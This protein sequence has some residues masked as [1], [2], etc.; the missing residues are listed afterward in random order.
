MTNEQK[1]VKGFAIFLAAVICISILSAALNLIGFLFSWTVDTDEPSNTSI[2]LNRNIDKID[3]DLGALNLEIYRGE[4]FTV[5]KENYRG[6]VDIKTVGST[7]KI[8]EKHN[9]F[10]NH[11]SGTLI[12]RIPEEIELSSLDIDLGAGTLTM[13]DIVADDF[14]LEHGAGTINIDKCNFSKTDIDGGVGK[15]TIKN[16]TIKDL[17]LDSGVGEINIEGRLFG[18]SKI[19][20]GVGAINLNLLGSKED[21]TIKIDKGL[22]AVTVDGEAISGLIG[23]G[24]NR[25]DIDSGVG[26]VKINFD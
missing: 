25:I 24:V 21:Y 15:M 16:S 26:A 17:D 12:I 20:G 13:E 11:H 10:G 18:R 4:N 3:A 14:D 5:E 19:D 8:I 9:F 1:L 6:K 23:T 22:G 7:L 2:S